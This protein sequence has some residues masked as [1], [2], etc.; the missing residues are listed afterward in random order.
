LSSRTMAINL[1]KV[2]NIEKEESGVVSLLLLQSVFIGI[3]AGALDVGA[4]ALF[5]E[6]YGAD[7]IPKAFMFSGMAGIV[8]TSIYSYFQSRSDFKKFAVI[9]L[10]LVVLATAAL[11]F[12]FQLTDSKVI[13]FLVFVMM[14]PLTIITMLGFWGTAGRFF[15][16]RQG[17]R[18]F[19][20]IDMG[21][22][23]GMILAFYAVPVLMKFSF[24]VVDTL[25]LSLASVILALVL[26]LIISRKYAFL[27]VTV[28]EEKTRRTTFFDLFKRRYTA[29]MAGFVILSVITAFFIHYSF[30]W[31]TEANNPNSRDAAAFLGAFMGTMMVF[32]IVLKSFLYGWLMKSYGLRVALLISPA[33]VLVLTLIA[34]FVGRFFGYMPGTD[35]FIFFFLVIS[36]SKLFNKALKDSMEVPSMKILYQSLDS[37]ERYDIQAR[38]DGT[39]NEIT[40][41]SA[42]LMMAG[43]VLLSFI[44]IIH[45]TYILVFILLAWIVVGAALYRRYRQSLEDSLASARKEDH[46][47]EEKDFF[48]F[49]PVPREKLSQDW[50]RINP[51][52]YHISSSRNLDGVLDAQ[53]V[54][55]RKAGWDVVASTL[56]QP[57]K[58]VIDKA[59]SLSSDPEIKA[60]AERIMGRLKSSE[61]NLLSAFRSG[62]KE[63][64][65]SALY[66]VVREQ[67]RTHLPQ[68]I[69]LLRDPDPDIR[70]AAIEAAG[71][72]GARELGSY[73]V[74][75][76]GH[77]DLGY[78]AWSALVMIGD[79]ILENLENAFHR[80]GQPADVQVAIVNAMGA[81]GGLRAQHYL[82]QKIQYH[83]RKVRQ[84][85]VEQL[86]NANYKPDENTATKIKEAV[87]NCVAAGAWVMAAEQTIRENSPGK[88]LLEAIREEYRSINQ[89]L[90]KLLGIAY[91]RQVVEHVSST[92]V[93]EESD[94]RGY[95]IEL[96][97]LLVEDDV[98]EYLE[99]YFDDRPVTEK[100]RMLQAVLPVEILSYE[101]LIE[102]ILTRDGLWLGNYIRA[103]AIDA[104]KDDPRF[105]GSLHLAAQAFNSEKVISDLALA[106]LKKKT[107]EKYSEIRNRVSLAS[108]RPGISIDQD[109]EEEANA[110]LQRMEELTK[111]S[112]FKNVPA[113]ELLILA[114]NA[115]NLEDKHIQ[116]P[117]NVTFLRD[118]STFES[119]S[120][121]ER[122][123][124][125]ES[126]GDSHVEDH[127]VAF[128]DVPHAFSVRLDV[129][130]RIVFAN[131]G[132]YA[133]IY[134]YYKNVEPKSKAIE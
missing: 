103:C 46:H 19:G 83:Q 35:S 84:A 25:I 117:K 20:V 45:F 58:A 133:A 108:G 38:I 57:D 33:L 105:D 14:G 91:D 44:H 27:P 93:E 69:T 6:S 134:G 104:I 97:N 3:F 22:I 61:K 65:F 32:T 116:G 23:L 10:I 17:K 115:E 56:F 55:I 124:L 29:L 78:T 94:D 73:L 21:Q 49:E 24:R 16:L 76:I 90:F 71:R 87:N 112:L 64:V 127:L 132:L 121:T 60:I 102:E 4:N 54:G 100:I 122:I 9:N 7:L 128:E 118:L 126:N 107:P 2:L 125:S 30:L 52:F 34:A 72:L 120:S 50:I 77:P 36:V 79:D 130:K 89:L 123:I 31:V 15:T 101:R 37:R 12:L 59:L 81:I 47:V 62:N 82:V 68:I 110:V 99:P 8:L 5:L 1:S 43:L 92:L 26:Q 111:W 119:S 66:I 75:Y 40:A 95:A 51:C 67:D 28:K 109:R 70:R 85:V 98:K 86:Y 48:Y 63:R 80:T 41:F 114:E 74:D 13:V 106:A 39:V 53:D 131:R 42:G 18:L 113:F 11:R 129:L 88:G 96:L